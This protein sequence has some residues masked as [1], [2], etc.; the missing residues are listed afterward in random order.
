MAFLG[1]FNTLQL[2]IDN[3]PTG[4]KEDFAFVGTGVNKIEYR[5]SED[6][7]GTWYDAEKVKGVQAS[8]FGYESNPSFTDEIGYLRKSDGSSRRLTLK[9][10]WKGIM[11]QKGDLTTLDADNQTP[12][13][14]LAGANDTVLRYVNGVPTPSNLDDLYYAIGSLP[15][16]SETTRGIIEIATQTEYFNKDNTKAITAENIANDVRQASFSIVN[17]SYNGVQETDFGD[18]ATWLP[19]A[20]PQLIPTGDETLDG[21]GV[22]VSGLNL[23]G[24]MLSVNEANTDLVD[25]AGFEFKDTANALLNGNGKWFNDADKKWLAP[26]P[27]NTFNQGSNKKLFF[28]IRIPEFMITTQN[29]FNGDAMYLYIRLLRYNFNAQNR[30]I[31]SQIP[32]VLSEINATSNIPYTFLCS[33]NIKGETDPFVSAGNGFYMD[34]IKSNKSSAGGG[35]PVYLRHVRIDIERN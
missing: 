35:N 34:I 8:S 24:T 7:G 2:L 13:R 19:I 22:F 15:I 10:A 30:K 12:I 27:L 1:Q 5:W 21:T 11:T 20:A 14:V 29:S 26:S 31:I 18:S 16:S 25:Y 3:F 4:T 33:I 6:G 32:I 17:K 23:L 28:R 9:K